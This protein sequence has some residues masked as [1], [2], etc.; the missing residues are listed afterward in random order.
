M[1]KFIFAIAAILAVTMMFS[2][3][4]K[5]DEQPSEPVS[6]TQDA[7]TDEKTAGESTEENKEEAAKEDKEEKKETETKDEKKETEK[8]P[9]K[10]AEKEPVKEKAEEP[11][12]ESAPITNEDGE[13]VTS[14]D[15]E[16]LVDTFNN[17]DDEEAKEEAR[18]QLESILKQA[19]ANAQ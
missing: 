9:E 7:A 8:A 11:K 4:G 1:K 5:K 2:A 10:E 3:C 6:Q 16:N 15:F 13:P 12:E 17:A 19:E 18:K 14:E